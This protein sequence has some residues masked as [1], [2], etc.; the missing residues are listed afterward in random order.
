MRRGYRHQ[1]LTYARR[2]VI[3]I[4]VARRTPHAR[5]AA[6]AAPKLGAIYC[7]LRVPPALPLSTERQ[8]RA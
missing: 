1:R 2:L 8:Q 4:G 6:G 3:S 5:D 7:S